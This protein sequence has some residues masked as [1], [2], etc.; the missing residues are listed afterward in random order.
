MPFDQLAEMIYGNEKGDMQSPSISP[1]TQV[2]SPQAPQ[3]QK[4]DWSELLAAI[5]NG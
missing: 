4:S 2:S 1:S 3:Q 5:R